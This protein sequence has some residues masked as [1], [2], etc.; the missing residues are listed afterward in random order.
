M[1][2][3]PLLGVS[4][5]V[6]RFLHEKSDDRYKVVMTIDDVEHYSDDEKKTIIASYP[7]HEAEARVKGIP[8]LGSGRVFPVTEEKIAIE[9]REF[10]PHWPRIGRMDFG[11][12]RPFAAV[13]LVWDRD[14]DTVL[15]AT[16]AKHKGIEIMGLWNGQQSSRLARSIVSNL[17]SAT[18]FTTYFS[19]QTYQVRISSTLPIWATIGTTA[20]VTANSAA[21]Y[22]PA[23]VPE[24]FAVTSGQV[25][26][27]IS[28]STSSGYVT[29]SET[30]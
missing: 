22:I 26:N 28:T 24:Y 16:I 20:V 3:T 2:F 17:S 29:V 27:Y 6:K 15:N 19:A 1:T 30:T 18:G 25:L 5:V 9:N 10:P 7:A 14:S 11:W 4:T 21:A 13:E 12:D 8:A 23:N